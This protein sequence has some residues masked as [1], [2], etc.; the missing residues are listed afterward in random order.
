MN[1]DKIAQEIADDLFTNGFGEKASRLVLELADGRDGGGW[2]KKPAIDRIK[3]I[4][5]KHIKE[6]P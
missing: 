1:I 2:G 6:A 4:L 5:K 3:D